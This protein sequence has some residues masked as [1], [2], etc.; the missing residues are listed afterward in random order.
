MTYGH[1]FG[2]LAVAA[3]GMKA[4]KFNTNIVVLHV[5]TAWH[6]WI[7]EE[8]VFTLCHY[9]LS[10]WCSWFMQVAFRAF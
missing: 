9:R 4:S 5:M 10:Q 7:V 8:E 6:V 2:K 1:C 3:N